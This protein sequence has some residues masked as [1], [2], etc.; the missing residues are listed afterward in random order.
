MKKW[1]KLVLNVKQI[2]DTVLFMG[3]SGFVLM[4]LGGLLINQNPPSYQIGYPTLAIGFG[5]VVFSFSI[6]YTK[7]SAKKTD[8]I[9]AKLDQIQDELKKKNEP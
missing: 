4:Y 8:L 5:L 7:E 3:A 2:G 1:N 6:Y 9:L